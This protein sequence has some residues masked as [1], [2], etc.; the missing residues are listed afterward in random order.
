MPIWIQ[1]N[2]WSLA[3]YVQILNLE[4][5]QVQKIG[6]T[7]WLLKIKTKLE[8]K[9]TKKLQKDGNSVNNLPKEHLK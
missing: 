2:D 3:P 4:P 6:A 9:Q 5:H 8:N 7:E 1:I